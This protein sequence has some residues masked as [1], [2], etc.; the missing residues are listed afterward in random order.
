MSTFKRLTFGISALA[1]SVAVSAADEANSA[2]NRKVS[3]TPPGSDSA[4]QDINASGALKEAELPALVFSAPPRE[5][6]EEAKHLYE[7]IAQYFSRVLGRKVEYRHP[8]SWLTYQNE[9]AKGEYDIVFDG[10]H[11][12][13]WRIS[14]L[15]HNTLVKLADE[16]AFVVVKRRDNSQVTSLK[17]LNGKKICGMGSPNLGTLALMAEF[18]P[19]RQPVIMESSSWYKVYEGVIEGRCAAGT[20]PVAILNKIDGGGNFTQIIHRS[21]VLPNQAF[22]AGPRV[23]GEEQMKLSKA[24]ISDEARQT[25]TALLTANG[26]QKGFALASKEEYVG[27]DTYLKDVWGYR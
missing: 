1:F 21:R 9:M 27:L 18:D 19:L 3:F 25:F 20:L 15:Q 6:S 24:L 12:N 5:A 8:K 11:F 13:S 17:N 4:S 14:R 23:T 2:A 26:S 10:P 22:S 16:H 7:P